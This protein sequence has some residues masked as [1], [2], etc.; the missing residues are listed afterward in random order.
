M[1]FTDR[2]YIIT[3]ASSGIGHAAA[4]LLA[5]EG[6]RLVLTARRADRLD[7]LTAELQARHGPDRAVAL[8]GD[9]RDESHARALVA[10][11]TTRCPK[12][13]VMVVKKF[14]TRPLSIRLC[15]VG[16]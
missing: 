13:S 9:V 5:A 7:R 2:T 11:A 8:P 14:G 1:R 16:G 12:L 15:W 6:A 10:L 4:G 3:G